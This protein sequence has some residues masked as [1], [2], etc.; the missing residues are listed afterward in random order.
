[1][2]IFEFQ[3]NP[4]AKKDRFLKAFSFDPPAGG[5]GNEKGTIFVVGDLRNALPKNN[6]LLAQV[7]AL[8]QES[9]YEGAGK[10]QKF[11]PDISLKNALKKANNFLAAEAKKGNGDWLGNLH[12]ALVLLVPNDKGY[13][14]YFT[15]VGNTKLWIARNNSLVDVG[16]TIES[17]RDTV[18]SFTK[19]F[20][21]VGSGS[22]MPLDR[23]FVITEELFDIF[24]TLNLLADI[25]HMQEEKQFKD[26]FKKKEKELSK[27]SG[28]L[29]FLFMEP[30]VVS[31]EGEQVRTL[32]NMPIPR[33]ALPSLP[34][35]RLPAPKGL[36]SPILKIPSFQ[37]IPLFK[38]AVGLLFVLLLV[39]GMGYAIFAGTSSDPPPRIEDVPGIDW[40]GAT[41]LRAI[42]NPELIAELSDALI[43][44]ELDRMLAL[45][46]SLYLFGSSREILA[47]EADTKSQAPLSL[48][49][50]PR[51]GGSLE[52]TFLFF[53][54]PN[55]FLVFDESA[56]WQEHTTTL[57]SD[58]FA[59]GMTTFAGNV[60]LFDGREGQVVKIVANDVGDWGAVQWL[61]VSSSR[62]LLDVKD[63]AIDGN[64]WALGKNGEIQRYFKGVY[65]ESLQF[66]IVPPLE[67]ATKIVTNSQLP[68]LYVFDPTL[69][70]VVVLTKF[71]DVVSQYKAEAFVKASDFA[72]SDNGET[73]YV[74]SQGKVYRISGVLVES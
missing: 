60:Y 30:V 43:G 29:Y 5:S 15:K 66:S 51:F 9:Y 16:K 55:V 62:K 34:K 33:L 12:F 52:N 47:V 56:G 4:K 14:M 37:N 10:S 28:M 58:F 25:A 68:Y 36:H 27:V 19:V 50:S 71:G 67:G 2:R 31:E 63:I 57:P 44:Q 21:S 11:V 72:V 3:F 53:T 61:D 22:V 64:I 6:S 32:P 70:R 69:G 65:A 45:G 13:K 1:M 59:E 48:Q 39:L 54:D 24:G 20:G 8:I 18:D 46:Q 74:F 26:L 17:A 7:V 35:L 42:D 49:R 23:V 38:K 41:N 40:T 73:I